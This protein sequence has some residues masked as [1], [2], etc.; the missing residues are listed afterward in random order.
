MQKVIVFWL[1]TF[2]E[3]YSLYLWLL[4]DNIYAANLFRF[5]FIL[6]FASVSI[7]AFQSVD[8]PVRVGLRLKGRPVPGWIINIR[9]VLA[10]AAL[11]AFGKFAFATIGLLN[12]CSYDHI[13]DKSE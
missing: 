12:W 3:L 6:G 5:W 8:D 9:N 10:I 7:I 11:A 13:M 1:C 4:H 2:L